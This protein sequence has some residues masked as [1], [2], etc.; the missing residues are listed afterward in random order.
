MR[1]KGRVFCESAINV[2]FKWISWERGR[3]ARN[4]FRMRAER[5][6]AQGQ[7]DDTEVVPSFGTASAIA[8][9]QIGAPAAEVSNV[10]CTFQRSGLGDEAFH[11]GVVG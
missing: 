2:R 3:P 8:L 5:P 1:V 6:R 7:P 4:L 9:A 10:S 11:A